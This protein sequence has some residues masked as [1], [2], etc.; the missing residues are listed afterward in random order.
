[1]LLSIWMV[2]VLMGKGGFVHLL[3]LNGLGMAAVVLM[4]EL[5]KRVTV[6]D[7]AKLPVAGMHQRDQ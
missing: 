7:R 1:M 6:D 3:L 5:R 4:M 2:L